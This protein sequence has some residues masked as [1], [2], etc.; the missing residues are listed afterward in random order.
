MKKKITRQLVKIW[1]SPTWTTWFSFITKSFTLTILLPLILKK[2]TVNDI[3][4]W[5]FF[6]SIIGV[7]IILDGGFGSAFVRVIAY[8]NRRSKEK[9]LISN[10]LPSFEEEWDITK[11]NKI[12]HYMHKVYKRLYLIAFV[13]LISIGTL[14]LKPKIELSSNPFYGWIL[15]VLF[16]FIFPAILYGNI[17]VNF[18][19]GIHKVAILRRWDILFN[20]LNV[21]TTIIILLVFKNI[22]L[23]IFSNVFWLVCNV[24][25]NKV[26]SEKIINAY[27]DKHQSFKDFAEVSTFVLPNAI[28]SGIGLLMSQGIIQLSGFVLDK[29]FSANEIASYMLGLNLIHAIKNFSQAPF[30][31][32]L[33]M[34][35]SFTST[36]NLDKLRESS[37]KSMQLV[38]IV[39]LIG[40]FFVAFFSD[41]LLKMIHSNVMFPD[42]KLWFLMGLA[43]LIDRFGAMHLQLYSTTN[44][45]IWHTLNGITGVLM[46]IFTYLLIDKYHLYAF[47][48]SMILAYSLFY[49]WYAPFLSYRFL[50]VGFFS[51]EKKSFIL[52]MVI[53]FLY[54]EIFIL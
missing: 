28:K 26:L 29:S 35:T 54:F 1:E 15:W 6:S 23:I 17:Y 22:Y 36:N 43:F 2:F 9:T 32:K 8:T 33:P 40:F 49:S 4:L 18:L 16:T 39:F 12:Y 53:M 30:Y 21:L 25:R 38:Y 46:I 34:F 45:I 47:P 48:I 7:Q 27:Y 14:F 5:Y 51:F 50:K 13:L 52:A 37:K 10:V 19:Q 41:F 11:L 44:H 3:N 24:I 31:S 42:D 20:L